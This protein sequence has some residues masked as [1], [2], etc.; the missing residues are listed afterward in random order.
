MYFCGHTHSSDEELT[1]K[2]IGKTFKIVSSGV[3]SHN[4]LLQDKYVN[5][6]SIIDY[7]T[8]SYKFTQRKFEQNLAGEF[9]E[10]SSWNE[11]IPCGEEARARMQIQEIVL[12]S[13][14]EAEEL[15]KHLLT[16]KNGSNAP[17]KLTDIFV[18][19]TLVM[20]EEEYQKE[21]GRSDFKEVTID[22][23]QTLLKSDKNY[24]VF[25]IKESGKTI[26][27][28]KIL[29]EA[30]KTSIDGII[31][32]PI[33]F[34]EKGDDILKKI[35]GYWCKSK[36]ETEKMLDKGKF[37]LVIDNV[38]F[39]DDD[40]EK[41]N[42]LKAFLDKYPKIRY[43]GA[44]LERRSNDV[45]ID[46]EQQAKFNY[47]RLELQE[48]RSR[49]LR[50]LVA[51][52]FSNKGENE[53][54][55]DILVKTFSK[56]NLPCTP[57]AISMFLY[58]FEKQGDIKARNLS[59]LI[60][61]YLHDLL[62]TLDKPGAPSDIFDYKNRMRLMSHVAVRML[63]S[64]ENSY[65]ISYGDYN[66][67][68]GEYLKKM[69][70]D[71]IY[72]PSKIADDFVSLGIMIKE[73]D[74][75]IHFRFSCFFEFSLAFA[76]HEFPDFK[77]Y[78]LKEENYLNF[79][80][81][82]SYYTGLYRSEDEILEKIL[83]RMDKDYVKV[84]EMVFAEDRNV[85][86]S[87]NNNFTLLS[88]IDSEELLAS[89]PHKQTEEEKEISDDLQLSHLDKSPDA[90]ERKETKNQ[91]Q[92]YSRQLLLAMNVLRN[93]EEITK[94]GMKYESYVKVLRH[95]IS[96]ALL[97]H[98][99]VKYMIDKIREKLKEK[100]LPEERLKDLNFVIH[101]L[102][103]IHECMLKDNLSSFKLSEIL[104]EKIKQ[105]KLW[106]QDNVD[107]T[108]V[109]L[110]EFERF[111]SVFLYCDVKGA[112]HKEVLKE[113]LSSFS[114]MYIADA[115]LLK[116][117]E[118]YTLSK[119]KSYDDFLI[120]NIANLYLKIKGKGGDKERVKGQIMEHIKTLKKKG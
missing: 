47:I 67:I 116:L 83:E 86:N 105:D 71:K 119:D 41:L 54:R 76:M 56:L 20:R 107:N 45:L 70:F 51:K 115:C 22:N 108:D 48:F 44:C 25:G 90:I 49:Q 58:I 42:N 118:Y 80:N 33:D 91:I 8:D 104:Q 101:C 64:K 10:K 78:V 81:E 74:D 37:L 60:E 57:F 36:Q 11:D 15:N 29:I 26:L 112:K 19:P 65:Q 1:I 109:L 93:S 85:D 75:K 40:D 100:S 117:L 87:F 31:P 77:E 68:V 72:S 73:E 6:F 88:R 30:L 114:R 5:G 39:S 32:I 55:V 92:E 103:V 27:L 66:N 53:E 110:S 12:E 99:I 24:M 61:N 102:P 28:D 89:L 82:I 4:F 96:Y 97:F 106:L 46:A 79:V 98:S 38:S 17:K 7:D 84:N 9:V 18:M 21:L 43:I 34:T 13:K 95:S 35:R 94:E 50:E 62:K 3:L 120:E 16:Y 111:L 59:M 2:S 113:F 63:K 23:I 69:S 14:K 52:W